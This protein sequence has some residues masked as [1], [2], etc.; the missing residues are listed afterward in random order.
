[1]TD[2]L[3]VRAKFAVLARPVMMDRSTLFPAL[4]AALSCDPDYV[5][6]GARF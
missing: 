6:A 3:G 2:S 4:E 1:M 5:P